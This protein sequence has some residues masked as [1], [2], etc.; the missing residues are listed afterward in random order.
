MRIPTRL[1]IATAISAALLGCEQPSTSQ[2]V[3]SKTMAIAESAEVQQ[4]ESEK[5]NALFE[6]IFTSRI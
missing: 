4:A 2:S 1:L 5:T 3:E 6:K